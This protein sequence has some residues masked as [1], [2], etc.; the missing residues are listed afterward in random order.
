[1]LMYIYIYIYSVCVCVC[2]YIYLMEFGDLMDFWNFLKGQMK[3]ILS[4]SCFVY[5]GTGLFVTVVG[6]SIK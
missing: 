1:M 6:K 4:I 3:D 2:I 5:Y